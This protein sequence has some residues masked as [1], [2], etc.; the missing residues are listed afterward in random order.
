MT[1]I[2]TEVAELFAQMNDQAKKT[3]GNQGRGQ[4]GWWP[5]EGDNE[6]EVL[7]FDSKLG[8]LNYK[9]NGQKISVKCAV[10]QGLY[11]LTEDPDSP[12]EP[13]SWKGVPFYLLSD[14]ELAKLP[15]DKKNGG[16]QQ[17]RVRIMAERFVGHLTC[18]L[19]ETPADWQTGFAEAV[20][21]IE[22]VQGQGGAVVAKA[23]CTYDDHYKR[24]DARGNPLRVPDVEFLQ[25]LISG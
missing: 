5:A 18:I 13:R 21:K 20:A 6:S 10:V 1:S 24:R 16:L 25:E 11:R 15:E 12:D 4:L 7:G 8:V 3:E 14:A 22:A 17:T 2:N 9:L 23:L 19:G